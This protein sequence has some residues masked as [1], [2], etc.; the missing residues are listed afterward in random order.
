MGS[1]NKLNW[2]EFT[3]GELVEILSGRDIYAKERMDGYIPYITTTG[4]NNGL[5]TG[6]IQHILKKSCPTIIGHI[7]KHIYY[8]MLKG[9]RDTALK[10]SS[11]DLG[12]YL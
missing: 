1:T 10:K 11:K 2:Q 8:E 7:N 12:Y 9:L 4:L 6:E 3:I 5:A